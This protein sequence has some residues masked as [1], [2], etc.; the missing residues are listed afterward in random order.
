MSGSAIIRRCATLEEAH[1][2]A[3]L[4][5]SHGVWAALDNAEYAAIDWG[6]VA[7]IGGVHIRV[8]SADYQ[9]AKTLIQDCVNQAPEEL[10]EHGGYG[11]PIPNKL[12]WLAV[13]ML[14][15]YFGVVELLG[16]ALIIWLDYVVPKNWIEVDHDPQALIAFTY[17]SGISPPPAGIDGIVFVFM[18]GL[19]IG[20]E[21][22]TTQAELSKKDPQI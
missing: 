20:W 10:I 12:R 7:A 1:I 15:I 16:S 8:L 21:L 11:E 19:I 18:I 9:T 22:L 3:G 17:Q 13:S 5:R 4:L 14:L 2:C 6:S